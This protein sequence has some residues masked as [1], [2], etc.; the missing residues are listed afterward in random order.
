MPNGTHGEVREPGRVIEPGG[1]RTPEHEVKPWEV[2]PPAHPVEAD[3]RPELTGLSGKLVQDAATTLETVSSSD[4]KSGRDVAGGPGARALVDRAAEYSLDLH[5]YWSHVLHLA[6]DDY[7]WGGTSAGKKS[8]LDNLR[9]PLRKT[10][11]AFKDYL[12]AWEEATS[13]SADHYDA[14]KIEAAGGALR[15]LLLQTANYA[16]TKVDEMLRSGLTSAGL[17][18]PK[19]TAF[20]AT[21]A[22]GVSGMSEQI[23]Q[24]MDA[25]AK[26]ETVEMVTCASRT[27]QVMER[28]RKD[29]SG[30]RIANEATA[31]QQAA[32]DLRNHK[33]DHLIEMRA[34]QAA[35]VEALCDQ[36]LSR[37]DRQKLEAEKKTLEGTLKP[38]ERAID[39]VKKT[40]K[41][42]SAILD[43]RSELNGLY[44]DIPATKPDDRAKL[45]E[46]AKELQQQLVTLET[47]FLSSA[48]S[49]AES[50]AQDAQERLQQYGQR[51]QERQSSLRI[52]AS[53][54]DAYWSSQKRGFLADVEPVFGTDLKNTLDRD[55]FD[56]ALSGRLKDWNK[57]IDKDSP[58]PTRLEALAKQILETTDS[59]SKRAELALKRAESSKKGLA[60]SELRQLADQRLEIQDHLNCSLG[61][62]RQWVAETL[63][64]FFERGLFNQKT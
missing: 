42:R 7:A 25:L 20:W 63:Q 17:K 47:R 6:A 53:G 46:H 1:L 36:A 55:A 41:D 18:D 54:P 45:V 3:R 23:G 64:S 30:D 8:D 27:R 31:S 11:R 37:D 15:E 57:E 16:T 56:A 26:G 2:P 43:T 60:P 4:R 48:V 39:D 28:A 5:G 22:L 50:A 29:R 38:F 34:R 24:R 13:P 19:Q 10:S 35:I 52:G 44:R 12:S 62:L 49:A 33:A 61:A 40:D 59:Y 21:V 51:L 32:D 14:D 9:Q 58:D